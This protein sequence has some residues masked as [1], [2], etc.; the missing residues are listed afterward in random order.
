[1]FRL[2]AEHLRRRA[3]W[4]TV[5]AAITVPALIVSTASASVEKTFSWGL[6]RID[7]R[8]LP[9]DSKYSHRYAGAGVDVY[10]L[11]T[12]LRLT[13]G[14]FF[15][16][17]RARAGGF[18]TH[19][20]GWGNRDCDGRGTHLAAT[21]GGA[22][23]GVADEASIVSVK[24]YSCGDD[25]PI[26]TGAFGGQVDW[27]VSDH[28]AG[29]PAVALLDVALDGSVVDDSWMSA[30]DASV[31]ALIDDGITVVVPAGDDPDVSACDQSPARV[32]GAITVAAST[33]T[34]DRA[35]F[36][37]S[38]SCVDLF[39]P[40]ADIRTARHDD[41][42]ASTL[43]SGSSIAAAHVAGAAA[44][45]LEQHPTYNP[46]QVWDALSSDVT[47]GVIKGL[48]AGEPDRL[49][50]VLPAVLPGAPEGLTGA[51]APT[52][53]MPSG[54]VRVTWDLPDDDGGAEITDYLM[55]DS[56]DG[57]TW[58]DLSTGHDTNRV[59]QTGGFATGTPRWFRVAAVNAVGQGPWSTPVQVTPLGVP[60][61]V[62]DLAAA[63]A[64][65]TGVGEGQVK[66]TWSAPADDG[67]AAVS[68]YVVD[69][70]PVATLA[71]TTLDD[72][73][74]T[75]TSFTVSGLTK[76]VQYA[77]RI[78]AKNAVGVGSRSIVSA[79]PA[80]TPDS[81]VD[82]TAAVAPTAG[83][84]SGEVKLT[85]TAP[86][87]NGVAI[88][89]YIITQRT[90]FAM[91]TILNDGVSTA[92]TLT[93]SGLTNGGNYVFTVSAKNSLGTSPTA[94]ISATPIWIPE[95]PAGLRAR[96][97]PTEGVGSGQVQ[98]VWNAPSGSPV[99]DYVIERSEDGVNWSPVDDGLSTET[100]LTVSGLKNGT[101]YRFQVTARN[102]VGAGP[103]S[104]E[105]SAT[106]VWTPA[107]PDGLAAAVAPA[108]DVGS[109]EVALSWNAP[110][111][112][113]ADISDY[114]IE[115]STDG[116][117][118][119]AVDDGESTETSH[120][121]GGL[122]NGTT[123]SF[124]VIAHNELGAGSPSEPIQATP[125][126]TP[127]APAGLT[128]ARAGSGEVQVGW[129]APAANGSEII[130][131]AI[132]SSVDGVTWTAVDHA[133]SAATTL[134][135]GGLNNGTHYSFR[136]AAING[137]G[138]GPWSDLIDATPTSSPAVPRRLSAAVAPAAGVRSGQVK[139]TWT[140]P[141][142]NGSAI[143][144]YVIQRSLDGTTW[145]TVRDGVSTSTTSTVRGL[146]NGKQYRFRIAARNAVGRSGWSTVVTATPRWKP[147][148]PS[149]VRA[150]PGTGRVRL[151]WT[152]PASNGSP[153][154]DYVIQRSAGRRWTTVR[155]AVSP[156]RSRL[157]SRL[158]DGTHYR[159]RVAAK[160]AVGRGFWSAIVRATPHH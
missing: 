92:T 126:W 34:D 88:S 26:S 61:D 140:A 144:D 116:A 38:G 71:W 53:G 139:L 104:A 111:S 129:T 17:S 59:Y 15:Y 19:N 155:D 120:T 142:S 80:G 56:T 121:V 97:A 25:L 28:A 89:D 160:N 94:A 62:T 24:I 54:Y 27:V 39:A 151:T 75:S 122:A 45:V 40:G 78:S 69:Y 146:T 18:I 93:L 115:S 46:A 90:G 99:T 152:A 91:P 37:S 114:V 58:R 48:Q 68:D 95:A 32:P 159:F 76:S 64:P 150:A 20:D 1:M 154:T 31:K 149:A 14:E 110:A 157:V 7:Q 109:G 52:D 74:G 108:A 98:L 85:W 4:A 36:S 43:A 101:R 70:R 30:A 133:A 29:K 84:G 153:I 117:T 103:P 23:W 100:A 49:L 81:P 143:S 73:I 134:T 47:T 50:H 118:W 96:V 6:D 113:G 105:V 148:A 124:R 60:S 33:S 5:L 127:E 138:R 65:A 67:G 123:Y 145:L 57:E 106:P 12:G 131:Y 119:T 8:A 63:V 55:Q 79:T 41:D 158:T 2:L 147:A 128:A 135:A 9:L 82:L 137:V 77:F 136:V 35:S 87:S 86:A 16:N 51:V 72:G 13:S 132:E 102:D 83:V 66:L 141:S 21:A 42:L 130:D 107:V 3:L 112:N 10:V 156:A 44:L 125:V 22:T 11:S